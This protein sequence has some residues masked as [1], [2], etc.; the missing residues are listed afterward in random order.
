M[1]EGTSKLAPSTGS[2]NSTGWKAPRSIL[3]CYL[4]FEHGNDLIGLILSWS[5]SLHL[6]P[7]CW[8]QN[9]IVRV[10]NGFFWI[11]LDDEDYFILLNFQRNVWMEFTCQKYLGPFTV[12]V[13]P[14]TPLIYACWNHDWFLPI[15]PQGAHF[16]SFLFLVILIVSRLDYQT[17]L[18]LRH[19]HQLDQA[20]LSITTPLE[21]EM[22]A[23]L[24]RLV[25]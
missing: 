4:V 11:I 9:F 7:C 19:R 18:M 6:Q 10:M 23:I 21:V 14:F 3:I 17:W 15:R 22:M 20:C 25:P 5:H 24:S 1:F 2:R 16:S 13:W 12:T 8:R